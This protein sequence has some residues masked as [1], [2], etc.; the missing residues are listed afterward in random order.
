M[1]LAQLAS[2]PISR[3]A[4]GNARMFLRKGCF[5]LPGQNKNI[6][7]TAIRK[8]MSLPPKH[9]SFREGNKSSGAR[10]TITDDGSTVIEPGVGVSGMSQRGV[11]VRK[12]PATQY[13]SSN[14]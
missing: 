3:Q 8:T 13:N 9:S 12:L 14:V 5:S 7:K 4:T 2:L 10:I 1:H 6:S 11:A